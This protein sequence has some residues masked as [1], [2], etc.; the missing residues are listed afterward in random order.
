[1]RIEEALTAAQEAL[2]V[3]RALRARAERERDEA[4]VARPR[5]LSGKRAIG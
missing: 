4:A 1:M 2:A 3:E 5:F